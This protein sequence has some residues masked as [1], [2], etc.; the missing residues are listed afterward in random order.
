AVF[1]VATQLH[2]RH[3]RFDVHLHRH[4]IETFDDFADRP[5][6]TGTGAHQQRVGVLDRRHADR[7]AVDLEADADTATPLAERHRFV[8]TATTTTVAAEDA[9]AT[10]ARHAA[11]I[12]IA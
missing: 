9:G 8:A 1:K 4:H 7:A 2:L 12:A 10:A 5:P 11:T 6:C 3:L